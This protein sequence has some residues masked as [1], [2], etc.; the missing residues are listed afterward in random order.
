MQNS[1]FDYLI[2][3]NVSSITN[4]GIIGY[5]GNNDTFKFENMNCS[6]EI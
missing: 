3:A 1:Y 5:G 2:I 6:F 4:I